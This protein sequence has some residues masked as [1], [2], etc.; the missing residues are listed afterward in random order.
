HDHPDKPGLYLFREEC[1]L[2]AADIGN[3]GYGHPMRTEYFCKTVAHNTVM[4]DGEDQALASAEIVLARETPEF[5]VVQARADQAYPGV[6]IGRTVVF[7]DGWALD[8]ATCRSTQEHA[9]VWLFHA[10]GPLRLPT[11]GLKVK[12]LLETMVPNNHVTGQR[13]LKDPAFEVRGEWS[14][15]GTAK[16]RLFVQLWPT[17]SGATNGDHLGRFVGQAESPDLPA[18]GNRGLLLAGGWAR[19]LD[20]IA[21]FCWGDAEGGPGYEGKLLSVAPEQVKVK[22]AA[23][24]RSDEKPLTLTIASSGQVDMSAYPRT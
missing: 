17:L 18:T 11:E 16:G 21:F 12:T 8:W 23:G 5:T 4:V 22:I 7:G 6:A 13:R 15:R 14:E 19:E 1:G 10:N 24:G 2:K 20:V 3:P 9:Y